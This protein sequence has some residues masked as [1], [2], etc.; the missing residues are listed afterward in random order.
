MTNEERATIIGIGGKIVDSIKGSPILLALVVM[1]TFL[2]GGIV[3]SVREERV[4]EVEMTKNNQTLISDMAKLLA[5]C[6]RD[7]Q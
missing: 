7:A 5:E 1:N 6:K 4:L 2:I 3:W